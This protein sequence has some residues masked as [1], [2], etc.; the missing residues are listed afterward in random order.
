VY[1]VQIRDA[2]PDGLHADWSGRHAAATY[3]ALRS[4]HLAMRSG[5]SP[6]E[7]VRQVE[8]GAY[9]C[10]LRGHQMRQVIEQA[11]DSAQDWR[12]EPLA[13]LDLGRT[14]LV[15][16]AGLEPPGSR[17]LGWL[18]DHLENSHIYLLT[19]EIFE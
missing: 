3:D 7:P 1:N 13:T 6:Y 12:A 16:S 11:L 2:A 14:R 9:E 18:H 17:T 15:G 5:H 8:W 10:R 4:F 19:A